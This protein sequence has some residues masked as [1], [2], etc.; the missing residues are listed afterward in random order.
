VERAA[1]CDSDIHFFGKCGEL[2]TVAE[3]HEIFDKLLKNEPLKPEG[4]EKEVW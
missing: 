2:P 4:W 1:P 3:L